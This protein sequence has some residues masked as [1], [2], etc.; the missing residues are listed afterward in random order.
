MKKKDL[1]Q[2]WEI[3]QQEYYEQFNR[4]SVERL[5]GEWFGNDIEH[6]PY[7][8]K[9]QMIEELIED[10]LSYRKDDTIKELKETIKHIEKLNFN[11]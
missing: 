4:S 9:N 2:D 7:M 5:Y 3:V 11:N 8:E 1:L 10:E 6:Y